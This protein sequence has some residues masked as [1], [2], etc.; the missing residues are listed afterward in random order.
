M[1]IH[2]VSFYLGTRAKEGD[3]SLDFHHLPCKLDIRYTIY[4]VNGC[5]YT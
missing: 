3:K 5:F 4:M 1:I 2:A